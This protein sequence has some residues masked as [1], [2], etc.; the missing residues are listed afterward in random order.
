ML[1]RDFYFYFFFPK[2]F[3][4]HEFP[5]PLVVLI[6]MKFSR[7]ISDGEAVDKLSSCIQ[8]LLSAVVLGGVAWS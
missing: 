4:L 8:V 3:N 2:F 6:L 7:Q 5:L 1:P